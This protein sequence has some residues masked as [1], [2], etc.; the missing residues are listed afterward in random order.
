MFADWL[1]EQSDPRGQLAQLQHRLT[2]RPAGADRAATEK[3][4]REVLKQHADYL[5]PEAL[6]AAGDRLS[7]RLGFIEAATLTK[8]LKQLRALLQHPSGRYLRR[9]TVT[10]GAF[11]ATNWGRQAAAALAADPPRGLRELDLPLPGQ[12]VRIG[13][14]LVQLPHLRSLTLEGELIA[15]PTSLTELERLTLVGQYASGFT[16]LLRQGHWPRLSSLTVRCGELPLIA[17]DVFASG[18]KLPNLAE[19]KLIEVP[20][21]PAFLLA[22]TRSS[23]LK[24][25]RVLKLGWFGLT[26][27]VAQPLLARP[28]AFRHLET[29]CI[30]RG[31]AWSTNELARLR[32]LHPRLEV[33]EQASVRHP[34]AV[35][36]W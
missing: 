27:S 31:P 24:R 22:L 4:V 30:T 14:A 21:A 26:P 36:R 10:S 6:A 28:S 18:R 34:R 5:L 7:W 13:E 35:S 20:L 33:I 29:L 1:T 32:A 11:A 8:N 12:P 19:L 9:L 25:L 23:L 15:A 3:A 17:P 2:L 16:E